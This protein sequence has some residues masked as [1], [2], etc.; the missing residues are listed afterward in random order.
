MGFSDWAERTRR[1]WGSQRKIDHDPVLNAV[2]NQ[3]REIFARLDLKKLIA[4]E[5]QE[6]MAKQLLDRTSSILMA[7]DRKAECRRQLHQCV[8]E[9]ARYQ[10]LNLPP[11]P[12]DDV[13]GLR[14]LQGIS[15]ELEPLLMEIVG[16]DDHLRTAVLDQL[17]DK[18]EQMVRSLVILLY[19]RAYWFAHS[20]NACRVALG[21]YFS[22]PESD[23]FRP[24]IH[25]MC[26]W[27][28]SEYRKLLGL[29][30]AIA[31]DDYQIAA[32][33]YLG[34][35]NIVVSGADDPLA[36]W[37]EKLKELFDN[38]TLCA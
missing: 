28:E 38:G 19:Q 22:A 11:A 37:R 35:A 12:A 5:G 20:I 27:R 34:F 1:I 32:M 2:L 21:D 15:G 33:A 31:N 25:A 23:W 18:S 3:S 7:E 29:K 30:P 4:Q 24:F 26:V 16:K 6:A 17:D 13:S 10:V 9:F 36:I 14:G 8:T